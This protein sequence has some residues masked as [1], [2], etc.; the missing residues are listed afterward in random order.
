MGGISKFELIIFYPILIIILLSNKHPYMFVTRKKNRV[1]FVQIDHLNR[2][3]L[4]DYKHLAILFR[5][6]VNKD[7]KFRNFT[8]LEGVYTI[9]YF[10]PI[11]M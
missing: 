10:H 2:L 11:L 3:L 7:Q 4:D 6:W 9:F 5:K 8:Y 1:I